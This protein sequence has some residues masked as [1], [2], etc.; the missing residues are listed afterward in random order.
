MRT[1]ES[2]MLVARPSVQLKLSK[3]RRLV[4]PGGLVVSCYL[5]SQTAKDAVERMVRERMALLGKAGHSNSM[6]QADNIERKLVKL[7]GQWNPRAGNQ[8]AFAQL[9]GRKTYYESFSA[10]HAFGSFLTIDFLPDIRPL[11]SQI[12][13]Q[14]NPVILSYIDGV[15][16]L[17][18]V[19]LGVIKPVA[20]SATPELPSTPL[21]HSANKL[22]RPLDP[23]L[24][25]VCRSLLRRRNRPLMLLARE[26]QVSALK[27]WLPRSVDWNLSNDVIFPTSLDLTGLMPFM[28]DYLELCKKH[29]PQPYS[30]GDLT[31]L[32]ASGGVLVGATATLSALHDQRVEHLM[33]TVDENEVM[34]SQCH[35]CGTFSLVNQSAERCGACG[36]PRQSRLHAVLD[37]SWQAFEQGIPVAHPISAELLGDE[38]IGCILQQSLAVPYYSTPSLEVQPVVDRVA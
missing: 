31:E 28:R 22:D 26:D 14:E 3:L 24:L 5:S 20:W 35:H 18:D 8:V 34:D 25:Q 4:R 2:K 27:G 36:R 15:M 13:S 21:E 30:D 11:I 12:G 37:A 19:E 23:H 9:N 6:A 16:Q 33:L 29:R 7:I 1:L 32:K 17:F 10:D 38:G